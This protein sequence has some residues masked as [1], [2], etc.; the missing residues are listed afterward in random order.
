MTQTVNGTI[1]VTR[2]SKILESHYAVNHCDVVHNIR[3]LLAQDF[4]ELSKGNEI[5]QWLNRADE[6]GNAGEQSG[7]FCRFHFK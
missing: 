4:F 1:E 5:F 7:N 3:F 6:F 2:V